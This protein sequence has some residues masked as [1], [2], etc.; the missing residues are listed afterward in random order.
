MPPS[1]ARFVLVTLDAHLASAVD[2]ARASLRRDCPRLDL[3]VHVAADWSAGE[4]SPALARCRADLAAAHFVVVTQLFVEDHVAAILPTLAAHRERYD[5]IAAAICAPELMRLTR[6]G[7][8]SMGGEEAPSPWAPA[9]VLRRL[10][11]GA[12]GRREVGESDASERTASGE[13]QMRALRRVPQLL[14][15]VPGA[16]QDVRAYYLLLQYWLAGSDENVANMV[17]ALVSRYGAE[18]RAS[19]VGARRVPAPIAYPEVGVYHP[20]LSAPRIAESADALPSHRAPR[21]GLLL[22]RSYVLARNTAHYDAVIG[23]LEA[24]GL[25]VVPAFAAGLD[26][27]PAIDRFFRDAERPIDALVSLTGFSLVGG[28]AYNDAAAAREALASLDVPYLALQSL[29]LQS[30]DDWQA[31]VRGLSPLQATLQVALPELDGATGPL[32]FGGRGGAAGDAPERG[33]SA[34]I[35]ERVERLA[36]RVAALVRLRRSARAERRVAIVLFNFPP[37]AGNVGTAA[38]LSVF[39]SLHR[40][41]VTLAEAGYAVDVPDDVD[42]LRRRVL[43]GNADRYGTPANVCDAIPADRYVREE[44]HLAEIERAWGPAPGRAQ[45]DGRSILVLGAQFGNV[46]VVVQPGFGYEGDPMRLLFERGFAPTHAFSACYRWI[47]RDFGAHVVLHFGT[48]GALEFMPG[49]QVGLTGACWP[50]RLIGDL[51]NVYLYAANNP[52]EGTL[53]KRRG[54]A[55]LV[56]YLTPPITHAGLYRDLAAL[57]EAL[58]RWRAADGDAPTMAALADEVQAR[59]AALDLAPAAPRWNGDAPQRAER[60]RERLQEL[61]HALIPSG[62]HV[63]GEPP[64]PVDRVET[65]LAILCAGA[66]GARDVDAATGDA[67][68]EQTDGLRAAV[69]ALVASGDERALRDALGA[70]GDDDASAADG[71]ARLAEVERLLR[72]NAELPALVRALDGRWVPPAPGGDL[73][74]T[75]D[76]LP[77]G[78]NVYGFDPYRVPTAAAMRDGARQAERLLARHR[79]DGHALPETVA[80]VLWGTDNMKSGGTSLAMV[81]ALL[82]AAPRFDSLGRLAGARLVPLAE[83]GRPRVDVVVTASGIFRDLFPV[84]LRLLAEA[85]LLAARADEPAADNPVR[86]HTLAHQAALGGT[87]EDA[88]LRVFSNAEGVYGANV[89]LLVDDGGWTDGDELTEAFMRRKSVAYGLG[90]PVARP[91]LLARALGG[92]SLAYQTLDGVET[93]ATDLDQY[94]D[95]LGGMSAAMRRAGA[96]D[97]PVYLGD[98][99]GGAARVRTLAEQVALETRTRML[100]PKWY[101][102]M[103]AAGHEGARV[104]ASHVTNTLGWSAT[105]GGVPEWVYRETAE[106][107]VLDDAMRERLAALNPHAAARMSGRLLEAQERGFWTADDETLEALRD[108]HAELEDRLE[109]VHAGA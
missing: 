27:R 71:A 44:P 40:T 107:Y 75:P 70:L 43:E 105:A 89:N 52:S 64:T 13:R 72:T 24:R 82:G 45:S 18:G 16:A 76:I 73:L 62:L 51:P 78:R 49:K 60:V 54:A 22:M 7:R 11:G 33:D 66:H 4:S 92:A 83:L 69:E 9:T 37:N 65:L 91:A 26:A 98:L 19:V 79:A 81:L 106:T 36:D 48:H 38:Y 77:T 25:D 59:A 12:G 84:Q 50:D 85:A 109:G 57:K 6:L 2:R 93:G 100:N 86:A 55:T 23:A 1:D 5:A 39:A 32:V 29:E 104:V 103:L 14:R 28:P 15:F 46:A 8:F 108:A 35:A 80:V 61:E 42:A 63:L 58:D 34:P 88:A 95:S 10:L 31:D 17:R 68:A 96:A 94:F 47:R 101:E 41:L 20:R 97:A 53:A 74:A 56:S 3:R 87:L 90:A 102:P 67:S 21:V 99:A 30:V